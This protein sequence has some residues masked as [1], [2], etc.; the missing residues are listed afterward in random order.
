MKKI[1]FIDA[2]H[3]SSPSAAKACENMGYEPVFILN[4]ELYRGD[5]LK[6]ISCYTLYFEDTSRYENIIQ[7]IQDNDISDVEAVMS[8]TDRAM[9]NAIQ[10]A[11]ALDVKGPDLAL[12]YL[13]QKEITSKLALEGSPETLSFNLTDFNP[14]KISQLLDRHGK[15]VVKP[16]EISASIGSFSI[17]LETNVNEIPRI[18]EE[19]YSS[20]LAKG[21]W[22]AQQYIEGEFFSLEGYIENGDVNIVG[23]TYRER[24][25]NT[26]TVAYFPGEKQI[27]PDSF[28]MAK[29]IISK[30]LVR[31]KLLNG[32]FHSEFLASGGKSYLIDANIGRIAGGSI[33]Q[34]I[35]DSNSIPLSKVMEHVIR[36][37]LF[38]NS[39][40]LES[41]YKGNLIECMGVTY[42]APES[43]KLGSIHIPECTKSKHVQLC[44]ENDD[45]KKVGVDGSG[46]VGILT[47][48]KVN[49]ETD[50]VNIRIKTNSGELLTPVW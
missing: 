22:L 20:N 40:P 21:T 50:I 41:P 1:I 19:T 15:L 28:A 44:N 3:I 12:L 7:C 14:N 17:D 5:I 46:W 24:H 33:S 48:S 25:E 9:R 34:L 13:L 42:G 2:S 38:P 30:V 11:L 26:L 47:G 10:V 36:L 45:L 23:A 29:E 16:S 18:I 32:Y 6:D 39:L 43:C 37:T 35:A 8:L 27:D 4:P 49:V 31:S